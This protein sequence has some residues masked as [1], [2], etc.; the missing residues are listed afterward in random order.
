MCAELSFA[1]GAVWHSR[2]EAQPPNWVVAAIKR[3]AGSDPLMRRLSQMIR[4]GHGW[5]VGELGVADGALKVTSEFLGG[6]TGRKR[7][8]EDS[9]LR[10]EDLRLAIFSRFI[11]SAA[12]RAKKKDGANLGRRFRDY[13][14]QGGL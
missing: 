6:P 8:L 13:R 12:E 3:L 14:P 7:K 2:N 10:W 1:T 5:T 4:P 9:I 11:A